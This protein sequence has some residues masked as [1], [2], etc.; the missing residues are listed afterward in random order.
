MKLTKRD[1]WR[2][3]YLVLTPLELRYSGA[4]NIFKASDSFPLNIA[5]VSY[6]RRID[7]QGYAITLR[8]LKGKTSR[9][10]NSSMI[11]FKLAN[12]EKLL[13]WMKYLSVCGK[14]ENFRTATP[15]TVMDLG[16]L[17]NV[18]AH[19]NAVGECALHTLVKNYVHVGANKKEEL[20]AIQ[21]LSWLVSNG[22]PLN[23]QDDFGKTPLIHSVESRKDILTR[24]LRQLGAD[25]SIQDSRGFKVTDSSKGL[26]ALLVKSDR[27]GR[28]PV[29]APPVKQFGCTYI[30]LNFETTNFVFDRYVD[31]WVHHAQFSPLFISTKPTHANRHV[32]RIH[33]NTHACTQIHTFTHNHLYAHAPIH[34]E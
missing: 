15:V 31:W 32:P 20:S 33:I 13:D 7:I 8:L 34:T 28:F 19:R 11:T 18:L 2:V 14:L 30:S 27:T 10:K 24:T 23:A 5:S 6:C 22:C 17:S 25:I 1:I 9:R 26:T 12:E 3:R 4:T 16:E 29:L 21:S